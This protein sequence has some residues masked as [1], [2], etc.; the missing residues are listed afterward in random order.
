MSSQNLFLWSNASLNY[1]WVYIVCAD[2]WQ[3]AFKR[4]LI[5]V[6]VIHCP[7][8]NFFQ[9]HDAVLY[10]F[11]VRHFL[12]CCSQDAQGHETLVEI[13]VAGERV[14]VSLNL[15]LCKFVSSNDDNYENW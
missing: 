9:G 7:L 15:C 1:R 3:M 12:A 11:I 13:D 14:S 5:E 6:F 10:E 8:L 4:L 2:T